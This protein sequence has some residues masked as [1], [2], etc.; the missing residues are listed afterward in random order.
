MTE[1]LDV[2]PSYV[3]INGIPVEYLGPYQ[4]RLSRG[5]NPWLTQILVGDD[6]F[7]K[8]PMGTPIS[9]EIG[10][11]SKNSVTGNAIVLA[12]W[13]V[14][15]LEV[16]DK[17]K[18]ILTVADDRWRRNANRVTK[19]YNIFYANGAAQSHTLKGGVTRWDAIE[20]IEDVIKAFGFEYFP[21]PVIDKYQKNEVLRDNMGNNIHGGGGFCSASM[22]EI[23]HPM[24]ES[25]RCDIVMTPSGKCRIVN[26]SEAYDPG[27]EE[28]IKIG[29]A[30]GE[31]NIN[32]QKPRYCIAQ[33]QQIINNTANY[34]E[35]DVRYA[36]TGD[37]KLLSLENVAPNMDE[38]L[39]TTKEHIS[40]FDLA[41]GI[42]N[43]RLPQPVGA[44][45]AEDQRQFI[46]RNFM[47]KRMYVPRAGDPEQN[48]RFAVGEDVV[49]SCW[50]MRWRFTSAYQDH[51]RPDLFRE[52][53]IDNYGKST[54]PYCN[55]R[56]GKLAV[57][58]TTYSDGAAKMS[59][60]RQYLFPITLTKAGQKLNPLEKEIS[61]NY[62]FVQAP[63][64][65]Q[66]VGSGEE[67]VFHL[68]PTTSPAW[69]IIPGILKENVRY[70][71]NI[72][73]TVDDVVFILTPTEPEIKDQFY[74]SVDWAGLL[75]S[76][77]G[78]IKRMYDVKT[79]MFDGDE[80]GIDAVYVRVDD[81]FANWDNTDSTG[82]RG[83][84]GT[85][86]NAA[87]LKNRA[88]QVTDLIRQTYN[89][90]RSG[91]LTMGGIDAIKAGFHTGGEIYDTAIQ[92]GDG[93]E[94][95]ITTH[96][97]VQPELREIDPNFSNTKGTPPNKIG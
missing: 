44:I 39:N 83:F 49:R 48:I 65:P 72:K 54:R 1:I 60:S 76:D 94:F 82:G 47:K 38:D 19:A 31:R 81:M 89:Q 12:K 17:N 92:I 7:D 95:S 73:D 50:R 70:A 67:L 78:G 21:F 55:I 56:F 71:A 3:K 52:A 61:I 32:F 46:L 25:I 10:A 29:G 93:K 11:A 86:L 8:L 96:Y 40:V 4:F 42:V 37:E 34:S 27:L 26:R 79:K 6:R 24:L 22:A 35:K 69:K 23:L 88:K 36:P 75:I 53:G 58:G 33:F 9:I 20:A 66:W 15:S 5:I 45:D 74:M 64:T 41:S 59:Y 2:S 84:P 85:L 57:D 80:A 43:D 18:K 97:I 77:V 91:V 14:V 87:L 68:A 28:F 13:W 30:V 63:V 16:I 90:A 51:A 62:D